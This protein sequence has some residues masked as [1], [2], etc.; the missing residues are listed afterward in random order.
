MR[1]T[2]QTPMANGSYARVTTDDLTTVKIYKTMDYSKFKSIHGNRNKNLQHIRRIKTSMEQQ[3]LFTV[4]IINEKFEIIDGQHRFDAISDLGLPLHY[5]IMEGYGLPE[6]HRLNANSKDWNMDDYLTA[7]CELGYSDYLQYREFKS[8]YNIGH[9]VCITLLAGKNHCNTG[10]TRSG[11][12]DGNF[13]IKSLKNAEKFIEKVFM[14]SAYYS[15]Y[16]NSKYIYAL[17]NLSE[18]PNFEFTEFIQKLKLQPMVLQ[19]CTSS[20]MYINLIEEIYNYRRREKVNL[21][22]S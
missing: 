19:D 21:R 8:K 20:D 18:N 6:V 13:K 3:Y 12:A 16:R 14:T 11:F 15:N 4:I 9:S 1:T 5:M 7:Y 10:K 22:F 17:K 2:T